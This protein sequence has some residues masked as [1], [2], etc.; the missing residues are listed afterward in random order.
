M[1][2]T[3]DAT[4]TLPAPTPALPQVP[5]SRQVI[6]TLPADIVPA[7]EDL[8]RS[9]GREFDDWI[10]EAVIEALRSYIGF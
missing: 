8:A 4:T 5:Q 1:S 9:M 10:Q 2:A 6:V 7:C 3:A